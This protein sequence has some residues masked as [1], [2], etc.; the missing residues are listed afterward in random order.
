LRHIE[1]FPDAFQERF[2]AITLRDVVSRRMKNLLSLGL[3]GFVANRVSLTPLGRQLVSDLRI[4]LLQDCM[5]TRIVDAVEIR[6]LASMSSPGELRN[7][8]S[9][10][11]PAGLSPT[12][13]ILL[14]RWLE[15]LEVA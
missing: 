3:A 2:P 4:E 12:Q 5:L 6:E 7:H 8:L 11:P 15:Q 1:L 14:L 10:N 9:E 13:A